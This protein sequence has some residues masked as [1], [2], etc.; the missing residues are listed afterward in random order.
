VNARPCCGA[1]DRRPPAPQ[2]APR[3][4]RG[5]GIAGWIVPA[6]TLVLLPKC[7]VCVAMYVA[8]FTGVGISVATAAGLRTAALVLCVAV[9]LAAAVKSFGRRPAQN[10]VMRN[11]GRESGRSDR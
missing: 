8:L 2:P 3:W 5:R 10:G 6:V 4:R 9:L 1:A 7:P 11:T